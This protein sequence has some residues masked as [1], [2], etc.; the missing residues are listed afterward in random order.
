MIATMADQYRGV[1]SAWQGH[2]LVEDHRT[3]REYVV[4]PGDI[5]DLGENV[6]IIGW[7]GDKP[8]GVIL[9]LGD[10]TISQHDPS[11]PRKAVKASAAKD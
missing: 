3:G 9:P 7:R 2:L 11:A 6:V 1:L 4:G 10:V 5:V 8:S